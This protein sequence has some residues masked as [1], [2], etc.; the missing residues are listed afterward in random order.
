MGIDFTPISM[1]KDSEAGER[2]PAAAPA[3]SASGERLERR[4][5]VSRN[6]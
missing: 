4:A 1:D 5:P 3:R 2:K 6:G